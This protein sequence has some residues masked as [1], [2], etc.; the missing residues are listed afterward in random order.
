MHKHVFVPSDKHKDYEYCIGCSSYHS[1]AQ[2]DPKIIYEEKEYWSYDEK[3]SKPEEQVNNH[4][5][6]DDCGISKVDRIMQFVPKAPY[7][8]EIGCFPGVLL[9]KLYEY[10]YEHPLGIEPSEKWIPFISENAPSAKIIKGYFPEVTKTKLPDNGLNCVIGMDV[11]EHIDD[12]E[13]FFAE[14]YRIL[15]PG[16]RA[17]FMSPIILEDG[18]Y[19]KI[20]MAHPD[21]HCWI[22]SQQF[23]SEYLTSMF[24]NIQFRRWI[25]GHE[26]LIIE[27]PISYGK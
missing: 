3:R 8:L 22:F 1:T 13:G 10:G 15:Y 4:Q 19:R 5:C 20:D 12:Y 2:V 26:V 21:E 16:G 11:M 23:L 24:V 6:I 27:K 7:V 17:I 18:L 14:V 9:N 25:V